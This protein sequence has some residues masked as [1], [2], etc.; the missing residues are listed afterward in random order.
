M[1]AG[2]TKSALHTGESRMD[3]PSTKRHQEKAGDIA[4]I[5]TSQRMNW[6]H[7]LWVM[8]GGAYF[9]IPYHPRI[10]SSNGYACKL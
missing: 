2:P 7:A 5:A 1:T 6:N 8:V 4:P 10:E 3:A 9:R